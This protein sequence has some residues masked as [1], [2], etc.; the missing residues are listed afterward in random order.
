MEYISV[1][2]KHSHRDEPVRLVSELDDERFEVRKL[3][4][5]PDGSAGFASKEC[6]SAGT[7]LG[8]F[9]VPPLAEIN[10]DP[11][12]EGFSITQNEFDQLWREHGATTAFK[13]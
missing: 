12:F 13:R 8:E 6:D 5:F 7:R 11:Q 2:W 1:I 10:D 9:A 3:E 4:F